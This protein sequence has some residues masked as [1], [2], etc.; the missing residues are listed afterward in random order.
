M[1]LVTNLARL[2]GSS[3]AIGV[4]TLYPNFVAVERGVGLQAGP[5]DLDA[6]VRSLPQKP[7]TPVDAP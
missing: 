6:Y 2:A 5:L 7:S 3:Q 4:L 1:G